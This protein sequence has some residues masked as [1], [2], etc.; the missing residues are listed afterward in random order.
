[1]ASKPRKLFI[2]H[3][4]GSRDPALA[5]APGMSVYTSAELL[6]L[7]ETLSRRRAEQLKPAKTPQSTNT[8]RRCRS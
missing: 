1:M 4:S 3:A 5:D 2:S 8:A 6:L 7:I